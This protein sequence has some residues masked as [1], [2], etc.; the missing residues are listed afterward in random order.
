MYYFADVVVQ[1]LSYVWLFEN[2]GTAAHQAFLSS[3]ISQCLLKLYPFSQWCCLTISS[4][5][6]SFTFCLQ[7]FLASWSFPKNRLF[8]LGDQN[9]GA[10]VSVSILPMNSHGLFLLGLAGL[11]SL[12]SK[13]LS[14]VFCNAT[15]WKLQ[16]LYFAYID[17]WTFKIIKFL[18]KVCWYLKSVLW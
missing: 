17:R 8:T 11:I 13:R 12:Q 18:F 15:I 2:P 14:R 5:A 6:I 4:S 9:T 16:V 1:L 10:S 7:S 3:T